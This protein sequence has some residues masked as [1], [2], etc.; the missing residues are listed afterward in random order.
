MNPDG[1]ALSDRICTAD[2]NTAATCNTDYVRIPNAS[3][4]GERGSATFDRFCGQE[5][6]VFATVEN[7]PVVSCSMPFR[8]YFHSIQNGNQGNDRGFALNYRQIP[9]ST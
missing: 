9:C 5:L 2:C 4:N 3:A 6:N 8:I 1:W 7:I